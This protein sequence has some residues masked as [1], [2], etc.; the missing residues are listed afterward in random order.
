MSGRRGVLI[1][2]V[3]LTAVLAGRG[4]GADADQSSRVSVEKSGRVIE[5]HDRHCQGG[6]CASVGVPYRYYLYSAGDFEERLIATFQDAGFSLKPEAFEVDDTLGSCRDEPPGDTAR[7]IFW[8]DFV[9]LTNRLL[10]TLK[11]D[12]RDLGVTLR[13]NRHYRVQLHGCYDTSPR[14]VSYAPIRLNACR[15]DVIPTKLGAR[16][17]VHL[18][19]NVQ[20]RGSAGPWRDYANQDFNTKTLVDEIG[21][22]L[23][24][25]LDGVPARFVELAYPS[26]CT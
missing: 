12:V 8:T 18:A 19:M 15:A 11:V 21:A 6:W 25:T 22:A 10:E 23:S 1:A 24:K 2:F 9:P 3:V 26:S 4:A 13:P 5:F 17:I 16:I 20:H 7:H 14:T